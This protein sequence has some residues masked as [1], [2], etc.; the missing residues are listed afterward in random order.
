MEFSFGFVIV[1]LTGWGLFALGK[2]CL[3]LVKKSRAAQWIAGILSAGLVFF[4][5]AIGAVLLLFLS[6]PLWIEK[7]TLFRKFDG[8]VYQAPFL[9]IML[10]F[11]IFYIPNTS[12]VWYAADTG[13]TGLLNSAGLLNGYGFIDVFY[14]LKIGRAHV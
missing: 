9:V 4:S 3:T 12:I 1:T 7:L 2:L 14:V 10:V 13:I 5:P 11:S 6:L 8:M